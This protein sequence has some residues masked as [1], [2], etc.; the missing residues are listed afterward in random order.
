MHDQKRVGI[1]QNDII[2][3]IAGTVFAHGTV[4]DAHRRSGP[5]LRIETGFLAESLNNGFYHRSLERAINDD[6]GSLLF[7]SLYEFRALTQSLRGEQK[8]S[9]RQ[10]DCAR[11]HSTST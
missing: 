2:N 10:H 3:G 4:H 5:V 8:P 11:S 9:T 6:F 7:S 1:V